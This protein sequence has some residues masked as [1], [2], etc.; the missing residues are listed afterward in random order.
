[1]TTLISGQKVK[2]YVAGHPL[3]WRVGESD[4]FRADVL[5]ADGNY[6][7]TI[8]CRIGE[9]PSEDTAAA[10]VE[11]I[12]DNEEFQYLQAVEAIKA[13]EAKQ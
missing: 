2:I 6:V 1:M 13:K 7:M 8:S 9:R 11:I 12:N 4:E 3:P 5:D 10:I